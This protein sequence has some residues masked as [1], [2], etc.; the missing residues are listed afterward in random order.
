M[1]AKKGMT[2]PLQ[3][4]LVK[5]MAS[6][7]SLENGGKNLLILK[8][9][10]NNFRYTNFQQL[11]ILNRSPLHVL[12]QTELCPFVFRNAFI[13]LC[14]VDNLSRSTFYIAQK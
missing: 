1:G 14:F 5:I 11:R 7:Y 12:G 9:R 4:S 8:H 6:L 3:I 2:F 13:N 10:L